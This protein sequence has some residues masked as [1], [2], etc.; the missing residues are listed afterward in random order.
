MDTPYDSA[1]CPDAGTLRR[2]LLAEDGAA[3]DEKVEA[4]LLQCPA[5]WRAA[6]AVVVDD[7]FVALVHAVGTGTAD[8]AADADRD[9]VAE[10]MGRLRPLGRLAGTMATVSGD[11]TASAVRAACAALEP[12]SAADELGRFGPYGILRLLGRGGMGIVFAARQN[13]PRRVVALKMLMGG[14]G[15]GHDRLERFR[16]ESDTLARL[17]HAHVVQVLE[18]G[19]QAGQPYFT[20]E[21][22]EGGSLAQRL[23]VAPLPPRDAATLLQTLARAVAA[24]HAQDIV[25]RDL[26][27]SN[28][29]LAA[30]GSPR[31]A[32]F[33]L[34]K[35][36]GAAAVTDAQTVTGAILGTPNYMA[37]E[38]AASRVKDVGPACD[39]YALG[40]ILYECLTGRPPFKAASILETL[41]QVRT[42]EPVPPARFQPRLPRDLQTICLKCL[43]KDPRRR[44]G[45]AQALAED[46]ERFLAGK[47]IVARPVGMA[48]RLLKWAR[49]QPAAAA[50]WRSASWSSPA[51]LP[52]SSS[53]M[54][55]CSRRRTK[56]GAVVSSPT[57][58]IRPRATRSGACSISF[59]IP[60]WR[61]WRA[62][63]S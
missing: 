46:L 11:G 37:P 31:I 53:P 8:G 49:R 14:V 35:D 39:V 28:V 58:A 20:M 54:P 40:A 52:A 60:S 22:A 63:R 4:H 24:A 10:L 47:P 55:S 62:S 34:A 42:Q 32:D 18:V 16:L 19:R 9:V 6:R 45:S 61:P 7:P 50:P 29:L 2:F 13:Q 26:K 12:P 36:Q 48:E 43:A 5:C 15:A 21:Y 41:E 56:R 27:P 1:G 23:A 33:G 30:D 3:P 38:Q 59:A 44:Y 57:P 25:H 17:Q 51:P